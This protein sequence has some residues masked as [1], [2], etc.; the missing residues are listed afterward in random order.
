MAVISENAFR[1]YYARGEADALIGRLTP[2]MQD[3]VRQNMLW[4]VR[5]AIAYEARQKQEIEELE[6][7][8]TQVVAKGEDFGSW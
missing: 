4:N 5:N 1:S 3:A 8:T 2:D 7:Y 6:Q